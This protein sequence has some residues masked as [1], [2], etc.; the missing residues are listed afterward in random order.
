MCVCVEGVC[1]WGG[2]GSEREV[3]SLGISFQLGQSSTVL[4]PRV[5]PD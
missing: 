1:V 5:K 3:N 4:V 2:G